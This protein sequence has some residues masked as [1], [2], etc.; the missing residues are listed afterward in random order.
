MG[1][2]QAGAA[3]ATE[4]GLAL[5][6]ASRRAFGIEHVN[7]RNAAFYPAPGIP[8]PLTTTITYERRPG[9]DADSS[10]PLI[11]LEATPAGR[12]P[13]WQAPLTVSALLEASAMWSEIITAFDTATADG[14]EHELPVLRDVQ[15]LNEEYRREVYDPER[16]LYTS[17][18]TLLAARLKLSN[19][20]DAF[21]IAGPLARISLN[22]T[23]DAF[24]ALYVPDSWRAGSAE[25]VVQRLK[26]LRDPGFAF[27]MLAHHA[28]PLEP[29]ADVR[30][31][32]DATCHAAGLCTT[33]AI[34]QAAR[35]E[36]RSFIDGLGGPL[37]DVAVPLLELGLRNAEAR[38]LVEPR[39]AL[40]GISQGEE[41]LWAPP[42]I[43]GDGN[44][45]RLKSVVQ[46]PADLELL[47]ISF[48]RAF[49]YER[50]LRTVASATDAATEC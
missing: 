6:D 23:S 20:Y 30:S 1:A 15:T 24:A 49:E 44:V 40:I 43:L 14:L 32:L 26:Q 36:M 48:N 22:L 10:R 19:A 39:S 7:G 25:A 8:L 41:T 9:A 47:D 4:L 2:W 31:W 18:A 12:A 13:V 50:W 45:K 16:R 42:L 27:A 33:A 29:S 28:P 34:E 17:A 37:R 5:C 46:E 11:L 38:N 21:R 35:L 3:N